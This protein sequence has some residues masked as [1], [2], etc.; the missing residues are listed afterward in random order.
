MQSISR[1]LYV[2]VATASMSLRCSMLALALLSGIAL[3]SKNQL[4]AS[5]KARSKMQARTKLPWAGMDADGGEEYE[6]GNQRSFESDPKLFDMDSY[7]HPDATVMQM[8]QRTSL[9]QRM[10]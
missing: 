3:S 9:T 1:T 5:A 10:N 8:L 4:R 7:K 6:F 2:N